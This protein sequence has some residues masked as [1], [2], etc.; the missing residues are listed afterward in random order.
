MKTLVG[1]DFAYGN[2][3]LRARK[4]AL[5]GAQD[6]ETMLGKDVDA[7][8]GALD[9]TVYSPDVQAALARG[10]GA[11]ALR[12]AVRRHLG[13][14]LEE[15]RSFYADRARDLVDVL[16]S[17]FDVANLLTLVRARLGAAG[18]TEEA[19]DAVLPVGW[20]GEALAREVLRQHEPAA[21]IDLIVR[22]LPDADQARV[23]RNAYAEHERTGELAPF[24]RA[25]LSDHAAR[26]T[27]AA[28]RHG[29]DGAVLLAFLRREI[30]ETN[31][32]LGLRLRAAAERGE[33]IALALGARLLPG[34]TL[35]AGAL[36]AAL[37]APAREA[38][39][40]ELAELGHD[41]WRAPLT[42][43]AAT[44]DL[45]AFAAEIE[46]A[47]TAAAIAL[48]WTGDPVG[49]DIPLAYTAAK[50]VEARNLRLLTDAAVHGREAADVRPDLVLPERR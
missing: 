33:G 9:V 4:G 41:S 1:A 35:G 14:S 46:R 12:G 2:T 38:A 22:L 20:P 42:R 39:S 23:V 34:G 30:D 44:G 7:L 26:V 25:V 37:G 49:I 18:S 6:Y 29:R 10:H 48:F 28:E 50:T 8:L 3:R 32:L 11:P 47:R 43:W 31:L 15:L 16:L 5:L 45:P 19:M 21:A 24:E 27:A 13:R 17:R 40:A 36:D